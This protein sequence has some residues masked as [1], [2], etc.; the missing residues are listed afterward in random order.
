MFKTNIRIRHTS[1][2]QRARGRHML[3]LWLDGVSVNFYLDGPVFDA[4]EKWRIEREVWNR[5]H[6]IRMMIAQTSAQPA[7]PYEP[8]LLKYLDHI[9]SAEDVTRVGA[10]RT[11]IARTLSRDLPPVPSKPVRERIK[12][13]RIG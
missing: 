4:L 13:G 1:R 7:D 11:I 12:I 2:E 8:G 6:A 9:R 10:V 3:N 5:T